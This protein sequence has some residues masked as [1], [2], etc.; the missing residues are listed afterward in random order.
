MAV[1]LETLPGII[2]LEDFG[3]DY[4]RFIDA[5]F[6]VF[7][8]DF[9]KHKAHFGTFQLHYRYHPAYQDRPYAFY[10]MTHTG[11]DEDNRLPDLRR[12]E[13][14]PWAR[15]TIEETGSLGLKF[16]EQDRRN[17]HRVC[18]WLEVDNGENY[19]V[20]LYVHKD[21]VRLLTAFYGDYP[22]YAEKRQKEY[23]EWKKRVNRDF[24]PDELI[25]DIMARAAKEEEGA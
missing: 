23:D 17:G 20:V 2:C 5:I 16:W 24:T 10:H 13:R 18:I 8:K 7:E 9:I 25:R 15:P 1:S 11:L 12:C 6:E 19:F 3:G 4:S 14:M 21:Y 22:N